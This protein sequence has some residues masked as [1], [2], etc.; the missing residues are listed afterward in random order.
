MSETELQERLSAGLASPPCD[1]LELSATGFRKNTTRFAAS[2]IHQNACEDGTIVTARAVVDGRIGAASGSDVSAAALRRLAA[3]AAAFAAASP[4]LAKFHGLARPQP[5]PDGPPADAATADAAPEEKAARLAAIFATAAK[6]GAELHGSFAT[7]G[8]RQAIASTRGIRAA[9]A[10]SG[11]EAVL[12]AA[13]G[14]RTGHSSQLSRTMATLP[15]EER[16]ADAV[17]QVRL[18]AGPER[19]L[20]AGEYDVILEPPATSEILE[21][22]AMTGFSGR[23]FEDGSSFLC[24]REGE[25][26]TGEAITLFDDATLP[27]GLPSRFDGEGLPKRRLDLVSR[28]MGGSPALDQVTADR[29][30]RTSTGHS[31]GARADEGAIPMNLFLEAGTATREELF[32]G[33]SGLWIGRFHYVNG[34]LDPKQAL[35]TGMTRDGAFLVENGRVVAPIARMRWTESILAAWDRVDA[36]GRERRAIPAWWGG[37]AAHTVPTMRIRK[38]RFT[39]VSR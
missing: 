15:L 31:L 18:A 39:G 23:A 9:Q 12:I 4:K 28:G 10:T 1:E 11:A 20:P 38:W 26:V 29:L 25:R 13:A 6:S 34:F 30:D 27:E 8:F 5:I 14:G 19:E 17:E 35:M 22:L 37:G 32:D 7:Y 2:A 24:G 16:A 33:F 3:R 36:L 21:W